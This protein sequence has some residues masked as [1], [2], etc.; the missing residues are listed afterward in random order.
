MP[1]FKYQNHKNVDERFSCVGTQLKYQPLGGG[2][3]MLHKD[4]QLDASHG[5]L[6]RFF[7]KIKVC[8]GCSSLLDSFPS[9]YKVFV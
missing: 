8:L 5:Y 2:G 7:L 9:N 6:V 4:F 1:K 3:E